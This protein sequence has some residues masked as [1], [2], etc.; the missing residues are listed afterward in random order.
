[1]RTLPNAAR[2][3]IM[4]SM[5]TRSKCWQ[6]LN[7]QGASL[8][9]LGQL[10]AAKDCFLAAAKLAPRALEPMFNLAALYWST[11]AMPEALR[12]LHFLLRH[13]TNY[14]AVT[15]ASTEARGLLKGRGIPCTSSILWAIAR[16]AAATD[17]WPAALAALVRLDPC[18]GAPALAFPEPFRRHAHGSHGSHGSHGLHGSHCEGPLV[19]PV[20]VRR[21]HSRTLLGAN[22]AADALASCQEVHTPAHSLPLDADRSL[23]SFSTKV[24][25]CDDTKALIRRSRLGRRVTLAFECSRQML[26]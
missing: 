1:M 9:A 12:L 5:H 4:G 10:E 19:S 21:L 8:A 22:R 2:T 25:M 23:S 26:W 17:D 14:S 7:L 15:E 16:A 3:A 13:T 11:R 20:Q 18:P 6:E 24:Q